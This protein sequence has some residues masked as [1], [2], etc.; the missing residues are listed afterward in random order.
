VCSSPSP[1]IDGCRHLLAHGYDPTAR[2]V[3]SHAG[4][5]DDALHGVLAR[6]A[7]GRCVN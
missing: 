4:S 3:M 2:V 5:D 6:V 7:G 1:F